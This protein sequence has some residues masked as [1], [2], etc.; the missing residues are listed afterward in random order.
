VSY[1]Y[2]IEQESVQWEVK[3][4]ADKPG[5]AVTVGIAATVCPSLPAGNS[6]CS[7]EGARGPDK[8]TA[9]TA[10]RAVLVDTVASPPAVSGEYRCR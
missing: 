2:L 8:T 4:V 3:V 5:K 6:R 7:G 9:T 10:A 1:I